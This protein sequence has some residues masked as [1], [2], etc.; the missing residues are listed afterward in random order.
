MGSYNDVADVKRA[1]CRCYGRSIGGVCRYFYRA[2]T[3]RE[4]EL[5]R[6]LGYWVVLA[7]SEYRLL[8][9]TGQSFQ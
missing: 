2:I 1:L 7:S 5:L 8:L 9:P 4:S 3:L 6:T